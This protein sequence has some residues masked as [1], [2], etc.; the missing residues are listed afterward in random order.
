M[1]LCLAIMVKDEAP[2]L[3]LH[4]PV[5][6]RAEWDGLIA[7]DGG[8]S[9]QSATLLGDA[10]FIIYE[11][12]S[13]FPPV[14]WENELVERVEAAGYTHIFRLDP[15]ELIHPEGVIAVRE[16]LANTADAVWLPRYNFMRDRRHYADLAPFYPDLQMKAWK[17]G[18]GVRY[19]RAID[20]VP[21]VAARG[22]HG[23][24]LAHHL[25][26]YSFVKPM[27]EYLRKRVPLERRVRGEAVNGYV[28]D[29]NASYPAVPVLF[30]GTQPLEPTE[31][32]IYAPY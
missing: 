32:G 9:D 1:K 17:L 21:D 2:L 29:A 11:Q 3:R 7:L 13:D 28:P 6:L 18:C 30:T 20:S 15:D 23:V 25:Y 27:P 14:N 22:L 5:W 31:I 4:L 16:A 26:H 8:S 24:A 10:G 19:Q 12:Q